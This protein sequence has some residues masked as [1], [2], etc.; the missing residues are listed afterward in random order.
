MTLASDGFASL[1]STGVVATGIVVWIRDVGVEFSLL[2]KEEKNRRGM[3]FQ[4]K[5]CAK[6]NPKQKSD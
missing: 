3:F 5:K 1:Q 4:E 2:E 6:T